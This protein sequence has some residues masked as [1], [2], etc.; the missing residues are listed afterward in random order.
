MHLKVRLVLTW[1]VCFWKVRRS[2]V[3]NLRPSCSASA[4]LGVQRKRAYS[5]A[6]FKIL[7]Q[8][9]VRRSS[10]ASV[11]NWNGHALKSTSGTGTARGRKSFENWLSNEVRVTGK[12]PDQ[13]QIFKDTNEG[14]EQASFQ[15]WAHAREF[16]NNWRLQIS[17][18]YN[19]DGE[20]SEED[21]LITHIFYVFVCWFS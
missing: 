17:D 9:G 18:D 16:R 4:N 8:P 6:T 7:G 12:P 19:L 1:L 21:R 2:I 14:T 5:R 13:L 15:L 20:I 10:T 3:I 11:F